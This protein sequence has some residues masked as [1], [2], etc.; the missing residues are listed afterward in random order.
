MRDF[1]GTERFDDGFY[2]VISSSKVLKKHFDD[3]LS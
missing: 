2:M 1:P 3:I